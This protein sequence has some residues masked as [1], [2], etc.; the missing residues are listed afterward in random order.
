[1]EIE[2]HTSPQKHFNRTDFETVFLK[3]YNSCLLKIE[4]S[5]KFWTLC[6]NM[7]ILLKL[8]GRNW[9]LKEL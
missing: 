7:I 6:F 2:M 9:K 5:H 3:K 1:M 8:K 4:K